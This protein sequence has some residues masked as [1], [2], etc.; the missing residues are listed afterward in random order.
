MGA[1][2]KLL[3][4]PGNSLC[5]KTIHGLDY[6]GGPPITHLHLY[7]ESCLVRAAYKGLEGYLEQ[8]DM[9]LDASKKCGGALFR[10]LGV[11]S[12]L[13]EGWDSPAFC[14]NLSSAV[15]RI[16]FED[17]PLIPKGKSLQS[18]IYGLIVTQAFNPTLLGNPWSKLL[19]RRAL[20]FN[21]PE[22]DCESDSESDSSES[23][24]SSSS[25]SSSPPVL[26]T[27]AFPLSSPLRVSAI[28]E[29]LNGLPFGIRMMNIKTLVNG[30]CTSSRLHET[31][32]HKCLCGCENASDSLQ[33][34]LKCQPLWT[35][36]CSTMGLGAAL[37]DLPP[38]A[39]CGLS[40]PHVTKGFMVALA[41]RSYHSLK[42]EHLDY[43]LSARAEERIEDI[44]TLLFEV[45]HAHWRE[46]K[47]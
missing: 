3:R 41:F 4:L 38:L 16:K 30:W 43:V 21:P 10:D 47:P 20:V 40:R 7:M 27:S 13:P 9:L 25:S 34:Y 36:V 5:Y 22:P 44:H 24:S 23:D 14:E 31:K 32:L 28:A 11:G 17:I 42:Y 37:L 19:N 8:F 29:V 2:I 26:R 33:H 39:R 1:A 15:R 12:S 18:R 45:A 46:L 6:M 35:T